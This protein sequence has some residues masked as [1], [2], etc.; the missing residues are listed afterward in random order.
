MKDNLIFT[1]LCERI[2]KHFILAEIVRIK[3]LS[4]RQIEDQKKTGV[5]FDYLTKMHKCL[6]QMLREVIITD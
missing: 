6:K 4:N 2:T 5:Q 3:G 1:K